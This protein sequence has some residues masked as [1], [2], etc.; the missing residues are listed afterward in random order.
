MPLPGDALPEG[1]SN[2]ERVL[3]TLRSLAA[4]HNRCGHIV[5]TTPVL[6]AGP[7]GLFVKNPVSD[8]VVLVGDA[9]GRPTR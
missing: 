8:E 2:Q 6:G 5:F 3:R 4:L 9:S 1:S 7:L